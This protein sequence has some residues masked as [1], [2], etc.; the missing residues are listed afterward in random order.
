MIPARAPRPLPS[1]AA[2]CGESAR[3]LARSPPGYL[4]TAHKSSGSATAGG[5]GR[6][7]KALLT[8]AKPHSS[9]SPTSSRRWLRP[10]PRRHR[11]ACVNS[12]LSR[13]P[14]Q[15]INSGRG[16]N[17]LMAPDVQ[18]LH[19]P[20]AVSARS[21]YLPRKVWADF[22]IWFQRFFNKG[23]HCTYSCFKLAVSVVG[24]TEVHMFMT[25]LTFWV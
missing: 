2:A 15:K 13:G 5:D 25:V 12:N 1:A 17:W 3:S 8:P 24:I 21:T 11:W 23:F 16:D 6:P 14:S 20:S 19:L 22:C 9:L 7:E 10:L 4:Q 18:S